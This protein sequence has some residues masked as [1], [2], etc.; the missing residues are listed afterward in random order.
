M[1]NTHRLA[2]KVEELENELLMSQTLAQSKENI[3]ADISQATIEVWPPIKIISEQ[4]ELITKFQTAI[5]EV[6]VVLKQKPNEATYIIK[7]LK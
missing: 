3:W 5:Q 1:Q 2:K 4:E 7:V 6:R